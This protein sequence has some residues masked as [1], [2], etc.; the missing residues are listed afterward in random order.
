MSPSSP[1][2]RPRLRAVLAACALALVASPGTAAAE[3]S[4]DRFAS[5]SGS[6]SADGTAARPFRS[7]QHL[8]EMLNTGQTGCLRQGSYG[9]T[10]NAYVLRVPHGGA[11]DAPIEIRSYPGERAHLDGIIYFPPG[12]DHV[13][14]KDLEI[15]GTAGPSNTIQIAS[16]GAVI[17]DSDITNANGGRSCALVGQMAVVAHS[18]IIRRNTFRNCG[19]FANGG[20]DHGIY[21][22]RTLGGEIVDNVFY[23]HSA[24]AI[25]L[26]PGAAGMRVAHNVI[27][28]TGAVHGGIVIG[29]EHGLVARDNIIERNV[30]AYSTPYNVWSWWGGDEIGTGNVVRDNCLWGGARGQI[31]SQV[32]FTATSNLVADPGFLDRA[33]HDYRLSELSPCRAEVLYDTVENVA[34]ALASGTAGSTDA[35]LEPLGAP[36]VSLVAPLGGSRFGQSLHAEAVPSGFSVQPWVKFLLDDRPL[37]TLAGPPYELDW[38]VTKKTS[39]GFHV[40]KVKAGD[41]TGKVVESSVIIQRVREPKAGAAGHK[42]RGRRH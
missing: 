4:C 2:I 9:P 34:T 25:Q 31:G 6:D 40:F 33:A 22:Q 23:G 28:G 5:P 10:L 3:V 19:N 12:S 42:G 27:D 8:A 37:G 15:A 1:A 16:N 18:P 41:A 32:G 11:S 7:V 20:L 24:F 26:Y 14:L 29:G 17:E 21:A 39:Y 35:L 38:K 36:K 30:I 13:S